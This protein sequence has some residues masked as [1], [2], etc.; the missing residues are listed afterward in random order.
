MRLILLFLSVLWLFACDQ[1][2]EKKDENVNEKITKTDEGHL[3]KDPLTGWSM[4]IPDAWRVM[5]E[6]ELEAQKK[7][8]SKRAADG[9]Y[10][11]AHFLLG[12]EKDSTFKNMFLSGF[13]PWN[14]EK[15]GS[16]QEEVKNEKYLHFQ[17]YLQEQKNPDSNIGRVDTSL[18]NKEMVDGLDFYVYELRLLNLQGNL[19]LKHRVYHRMVGKVLFFAIITFNNNLD[20]KVL[21]KAWMK[22]DFSKR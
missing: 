19:K 9:Y 7:A 21:W 13:A 1:K 12:F 14:E 10:Q 6:A 20:K 16:V 5:T 11:D 2:E 3:Y 18:T 17:S 8:I 15:N 22:S 4:H